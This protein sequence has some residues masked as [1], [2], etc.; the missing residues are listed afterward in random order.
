VGRRVQI[1]TT[2]GRVTVSLTGT[3]VEVPGGDTA[4]LHTVLSVTVDGHRFSR[5]V[6]PPAQAEGRVIPWDIAPPPADAA[7]TPQAPNSDALCLARFPGETMPTV[8]IGLFTGGAHCC[9]VVR[10]MTLSSAG[11]GPSIDD[12]LG[13]AGTS[14][15]RE[16]DYAL[17]VT[18]D[19][20]FAYAFTDYADSGMPIRVLQF[21]RGGF[22][23]VTMH[24]L[25]LVAG[26]ASIWWNGFNRDRANGLGLLAAWVADECVLG[27]SHS[28]WAT[29]DHLEADGRLVAPAGWPE[30][31]AFVKKLKSFL[32]KHQYC[33]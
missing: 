30:E 25:A 5:L 19:N 29:V 7:T 31:A 16:G 21:L 14:L 17:I 13:N 3:T 12:D 1:V 4:L 26:D 24:H 23:D 33:S 22:A 2:L 18:A 9:T 28:A 11:P 10:A 32:M 8:L 20:N 15:R 6:A 27:H